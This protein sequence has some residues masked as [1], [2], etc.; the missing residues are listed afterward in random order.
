MDHTSD[1]IDRYTKWLQ[2]WVSYHSFR[3]LDDD[4]SWDV[5]FFW[6]LILSLG[7]PAVLVGSLV[8]A[9]PSRDGLII[10]ADR[11]RIIGDQVEDN[12]GKL[13]LIRPGLALTVTGYTSG[14]ARNCVELSGAQPPLFTA[15]IPDGGV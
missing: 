9:I 8:V 10:C 11:R 2:E 6:A 3:C 14:D 4:K 12:F 13:F 1:K 5:V 15:I 7:F